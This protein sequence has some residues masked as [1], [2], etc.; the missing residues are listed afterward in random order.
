ME[1][2]HQKLWLSWR[3]GIPSER[4][5]Q[6]TENVNNRRQKLWFKLWSPG[7]LAENEAGK[8]HVHTGPWIT[9]HCFPNQWVFSSQCACSEQGFEHKSLTSCFIFF[10]LLFSTKR[11]YKIPDHPKGEWKI[12]KYVSRVLLDGNSVSYAALHSILGRWQ[13]GI[14]RL[15]EVSYLRQLD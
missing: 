14:V 15:C 6:L 9:F 7:E 1:S 10:P 2:I 4:E 11:L 5:N 12:Q 13:S 8:L 3:R